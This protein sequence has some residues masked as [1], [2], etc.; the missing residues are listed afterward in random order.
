MTMNNYVLPENNPEYEGRI[1]AIGFGLNE[2]QQE[3]IAVLWEWQ[4]R[5]LRSKMVLGGPFNGLD[6][7]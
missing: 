1:G 4:E 6:K 5:S 7:L 3:A 2:E